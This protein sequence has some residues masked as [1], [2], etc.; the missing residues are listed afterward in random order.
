MLDAIIA[1]FTTILSFIKAVHQCILHSTQ[2]NCSSAK[3]SNSFLLSYGS[4]RVQS[5][6]PLTMRF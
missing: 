5:L 1:S 3:L 2:S 4:I 6:T